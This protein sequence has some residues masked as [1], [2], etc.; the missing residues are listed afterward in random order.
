MNMTLQNGFQTR[1]IE[2]SVHIENRDYI[3]AQDKFESI[4]TIY[5]SPESQRALK[6]Q[7]IDDIR[8]MLADETLAVEKMP[9]NE[10][11]AEKNI[12]ESWIL[13]QLLFSEDPEY[14]D[15]LREMYKESGQFTESDIEFNCI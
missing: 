12:G 5:N 10:A 15:I 4:I 3:A 1:L 11:I 14:F 9:E 13:T 8:E 7:Y 2:L 6:K